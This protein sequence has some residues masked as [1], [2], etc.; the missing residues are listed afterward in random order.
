MNAVYLKALFFC[1]SSPRYAIE[2]H[3]IEGRGSVV[4]FSIGVVWGVAV[5]VMR[6]S[7]VI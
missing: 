5:G 2:R 6:L 1:G 7:I 3:E 4:A